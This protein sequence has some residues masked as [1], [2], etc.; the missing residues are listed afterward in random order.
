MK[1][2]GVGVTRL[3]WSADWG[4]ET[5]ERSTMPPLNRTAPP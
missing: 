4:S 2:E 3:G 1:G 5:A